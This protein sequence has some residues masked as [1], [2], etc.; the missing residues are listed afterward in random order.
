MKEM[1]LAISE[2]DGLSHNTSPTPVLQTIPSYEIL[3][4]YIQ[5]ELLISCEGVD[6]FIL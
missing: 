4:K 2:G 5:K 3:L 1:D 6:T